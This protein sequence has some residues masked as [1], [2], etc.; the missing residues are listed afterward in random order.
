[1]KQVNGFPTSPR[2]FSD[3]SPQHVRDK[4][5]ST[6]TQVP[7]VQADPP[8]QPVRTPPLF[9]QMPS[10]EPGVSP[11]LRPPARSA[12][13]VKRVSLLQKL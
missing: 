8:E 7:P 9:V 6:P 13:N 1:M 11:P 12:V 4:R 3:F 10:A 5:H 2:H